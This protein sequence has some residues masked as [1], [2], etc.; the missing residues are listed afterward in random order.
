MRCYG[1][2]ATNP[3]E[4]AVCQVQAAKSLTKKSRAASPGFLF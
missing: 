4:G 2:A 3:E 1:D